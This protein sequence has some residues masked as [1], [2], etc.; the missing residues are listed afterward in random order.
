VHFTIIRFGQPAVAKSHYG[1]VGY[2]GFNAALTCRK[3]YRNIGM[4]GLMQVLKMQ[5]VRVAVWDK[6]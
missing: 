1:Q 4:F 2:R 6:G 3:V 5:F